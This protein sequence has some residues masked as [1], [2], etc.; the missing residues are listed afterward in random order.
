MHIS[1]L[2]LV[3]KIKIPEERTGNRFKL[4]VI[5]QFLLFSH[6]LGTLRL[7]K[8]KQHWCAINEDLIY[9]KLLHFSNQKQFYGMLHDMLHLSPDNSLGNVETSGSSFAC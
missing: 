2:S 5:V 1:T 7:I 8:V 4:G 6:Q 9:Y 3:K